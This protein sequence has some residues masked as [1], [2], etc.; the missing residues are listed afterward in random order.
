MFET[1][2]ITPLLMIIPV[3]FC[4]KILRHLCAQRTHNDANRAIMLNVSSILICYLSLVICNTYFEVVEFVWFHENQSGDWEDLLY[5]L[6][7]Y[8]IY[9]L[10]LYGI[11]GI[12]L[13]ILRFQEPY[14]KR[15]FK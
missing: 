14:V 12:P 10:F 8:N 11:S 13:A 2:I 5:K 7:R 9:Y 6:K 3:L 4:I 1:A 15:E